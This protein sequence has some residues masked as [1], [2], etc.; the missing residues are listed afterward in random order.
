MHIVRV[1]DI[2]CNFYI[3]LEGKNGTVK[4]VEISTSDAYSKTY[5]QN[6]KHN[7]VTN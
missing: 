7:L 3:L 2:K 1:Y 5:P 4:F 6:R